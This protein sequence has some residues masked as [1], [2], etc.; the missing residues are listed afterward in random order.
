MRQ[1][2][3]Q[4]PATLARCVTTWEMP[5]RKAEDRRVGTA[6]LAASG[7]QDEQRAET[8]QPTLPGRAAGSARAISSRLHGGDRV[9]LAATGWTTSTAPAEPVMSPP[10]T[11]AGDAPDHEAAMPA[12]GRPEQGV[13][14][15]DVDLAKES[16]RSIGVVSALP[17][18]PGSLPYGARQ[19]DRCA[20]GLR[21][22]CSGV[23]FLESTSFFS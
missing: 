4:H 14:S 12:C 6:L 3:R 19:L 13:R 8:A 15:A 18:G 16:G 5:G 17:A 23:L 9:C 10:Y 1:D 21:V 20:P 2:G 22:C 7:Q 11:C